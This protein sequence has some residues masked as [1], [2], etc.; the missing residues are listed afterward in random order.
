MSSDILKS[1]RNAPNPKDNEPVSLDSPFLT[2]AG[3]GY[4]YQKH[5]ISIP[6][7][8]GFFSAGP[9]NEQVRQGVLFVML[10][11]TVLL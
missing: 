3:R 10:F 2:I 6:D 11:S 8:Y 4:W 5:I 7:R 9:P 1:K